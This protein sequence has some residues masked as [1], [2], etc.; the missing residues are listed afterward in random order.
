M[1]T[2]P[3]SLLKQIMPWSDRIVGIGLGDTDVGNPPSKFVNF[4]PACRDRAFRTTIHAGEGGPASYVREAVKLLG[5]DRIAHGN[6]CQSDSTL[7]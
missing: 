3:L 6:A 1:A 5:F 7:V 2:G 4:F